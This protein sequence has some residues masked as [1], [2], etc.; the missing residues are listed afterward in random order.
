MFTTST[1]LTNMMAFKGQDSV[2]CCVTIATQ[3]PDISAHTGIYQ[4]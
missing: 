1:Q 3:Q 2:G 4:M